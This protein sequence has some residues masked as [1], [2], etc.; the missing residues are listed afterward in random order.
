MRAALPHNLGVRRIGTTRRTGLA[1]VAAC[2]LSLLV[3]CDQSTGTR[4]LD[5]GS[6][7]VRPSATASPGPHVGGAARRPAVEGLPRCGGGDLRATWGG[8]DGLTGAVGL[9]DIV[10]RNVGS[11]GCYVIGKPDTWFI[12]ARGDAEPEGQAPLDGV[13]PPRQRIGLAAGHPSHRVGE[14]FETISIS[15]R[16][17]SAPDSRC[18][19][20]V[21]RL[22]ALQFVLS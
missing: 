1:L 10:F 13:D 14:A 17:L 18:R 21:V 12:D 8:T 2:L 16:D 3:A 19:T 9:V 11:R 6:P 15:D 22:V 20:R 7:P 4:A 5:P